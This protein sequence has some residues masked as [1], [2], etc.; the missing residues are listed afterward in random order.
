MVAPDMYGK[1]L[2]GSGY[3]ELRESMTCL[4]FLFSFLIFTFYNF[5]YIF[6]LHHCSAICWDFI[7][8]LICLDLCVIFLF[9][10]VIIHFALRQCSI[11]DCCNVCR[12]TFYD[13]YLRNPVVAFCNRGVRLGCF[14]SPRSTSS[15]IFFSANNIMVCSVVSFS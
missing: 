4:P 11:W 2:Y 5:C 10:S 14:S 7:L 3:T 8:R 12:G 1:I 13:N 15:F 6:I 9:V